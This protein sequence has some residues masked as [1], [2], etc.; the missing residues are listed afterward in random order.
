[1]IRSRLIFGLSVAALA[2]VQPVWAQ[3]APDP[4]RLPRP[5]GGP[6][7]QGGNGGPGRGGPP[8][9]EENHRHHHSGVG[10]A[11]GA[12][13]VGGLVGGALLNGQRR[14]PDYEPGAYAPPPPPPAYEADDEPECRIVRKPVFDEDGEIV[15]YR[16]RR[17][18]R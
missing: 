18:C 6:P 14:G 16:T 5:Q 13:V 4:D 11:I 7:A 1:M 8:Q 2:S 12:G 9:Q 17:I 3:G 10:A 15:S